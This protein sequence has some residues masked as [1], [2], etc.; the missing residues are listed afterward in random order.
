MSYEPRPEDRF[1]VGLWCTAYNGRE[2]FGGASRPA[3]DP[4]A[5]IRSLA[6]F[7]VFGFNFHEEGLVP[8]GSSVAETDRVAAATRRV[9]DETS[10]VNAM[11]TCNIFERPVFKG[12]ALTSR[13]YAPT[14]LARTRITP[15]SALLM[16]GGAQS[17]TWGQLCADWSQVP[18]S[19]PN[20]REAAAR[21]AESQAASAV[22]DKG[23]GSPLAN[24]AVW[25]PRGGAKLLD[26]SMRYRELLERVS[27]RSISIQEVIA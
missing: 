16:G 24:N 17:S 18:V 14:A 7:G 27:G 15:G 9:M 19:R 20:V 1:T 11:V 10:V 2:V 4:L 5:N 21:G 12:G 6:P 8:F 3:L 23:F 13:A 26:V 25:R 22:D